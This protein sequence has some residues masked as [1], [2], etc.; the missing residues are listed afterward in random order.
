MSNAVLYS[1]PL[2]ALNTAHPLL[3]EI[4]SELQQPER[5]FTYLCGHDTNLASVLAALGV[6]DYT[7]TGSLESDIPIGSKMVMEKWQGQDGKDYVAINLC[8]QSVEQLR[9]MPL[10]SLENPPMVCPLHFEGLT[11]NADGLYL[12]SDFEQLLAERIA[13]YDNLTT[14]VESVRP[15][16]ST[17]TSSYRIDGTPA[18]E[19]TRGIV[20]KDSQKYLRK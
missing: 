20:I 14:A 9:Q 2:I 12:L 3:Q 1:A 13:Q 18:T 11:A 6:E 19:N 4:L 16:Q 17:S 5:K 8:Y 7:L 10:L 15:A